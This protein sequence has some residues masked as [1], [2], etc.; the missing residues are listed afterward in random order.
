MTDKII[1]NAGTEI[2][3]PAD[4]NESVNT[5]LMPIYVLDCMH[6]TFDTYIKPIECKR[7]LKMHK[8]QWMR[9]YMSMVNTCFT[10]VDDE[11][12]DMIID[13]MDDFDSYIH[14]DLMM[15]VVAIVNFLSSTDISIPYEKKKTIAACL[16]C[17]ILIQIAQAYF[18]WLKCYQAASNL[19][20]MRHHSERFMNLYYKGGNDIDCNRCDE[21]TKA[22]QNLCKKTTK[23]MLWAAGKPTSSDVG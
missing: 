17:S 4:E 18:N 15:V 6:Q 1:I 21:I 7:E 5:I 3:A 22:V 8:Q 20:T 2:V 13:R 16:T 11:T 9:N 19:K 10:T 23:F 12:R 14:N